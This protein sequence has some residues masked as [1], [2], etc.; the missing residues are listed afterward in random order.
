MSNV[1]FMEKLLD[2]VEVEWKPLS[3][4][5]HL[6]NGYTPSKSKKEFWE[7]GTIPWFRMDDIRKNG[8]ILQESLQKVT[9]NAVKGGREISCQFNNRRNICDNWRACFDYR[10]LSSKS[11]IY[12]FKP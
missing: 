7:N 5:F 1:S 9:E 12:V 6:K 11:K 8:Q 4:I 3:E 2:R 10:S